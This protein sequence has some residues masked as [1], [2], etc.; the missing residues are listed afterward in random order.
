MKKGL[1]LLN[2]RLSLANLDYKFV[3]NIHDEWQIEVRECQANRV[4]QLAVESII[5]AGTYFGMRCPLDGEYKIGENWSE[6]H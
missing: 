4:G 6:T 5:D 1:I 3:G 2:T